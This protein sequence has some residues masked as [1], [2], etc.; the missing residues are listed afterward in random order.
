M[1]IKITRFDG[2]LKISPNPAYVSKFLRYHHREMRS[3]QYKRECVFSE[4]L[5][6]A[7]DTNGDAYTLPGFYADLV[8]L[9]GKNMDVLEVE[10][11]RTPLP[12]PD[13]N[14]VKKIKLRD[15]QVQP[16]IDLLF[17]GQHESGVINA[18]GGFGSCQYYLRN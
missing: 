9:I 6:Y 14:A 1:K 11:F 4:K 5:L 16:V 17:R 18:A 12:E 8:K 7:T 2:G 13:W 3:I 10:D 15:Y